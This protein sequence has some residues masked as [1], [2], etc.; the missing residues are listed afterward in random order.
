MKPAND[1][2]KRLGWFVALWA[3]GVVGLAVFGFLIKLLLAV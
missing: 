2:L 3:F 1:G